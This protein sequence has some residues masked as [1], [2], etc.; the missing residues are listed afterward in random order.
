[1]SESFKRKFSIW[2]VL[3]ILCAIVLFG[4]GY[5]TDF[6]YHLIVPSIYLIGRGLGRR[7]AIKTDLKNA[8]DYCRVQTSRRSLVLRI[9]LAVAACMLLA[10]GF[11]Y[12]KPYLPE[13][14]KSEFGYLIVTGL[15]YSL[16]ISRLQNF[17]NGI[18]WYVSGI[19]LPGER[20]LLIPW[21]HVSDARIDD[22]FIYLTVLDK[23]H[24]F[25][26]NPDDYRSALHFVRWY[27]KK[28]AIETQPSQA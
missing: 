4:S 7:S 23:Q 11:E 9:I 28:K 24:K 22:G 6:H 25:D 20:S 17:T 10:Y 5:L 14:G 16:T 2:D 18:R 27:E 1:M 8:V 21:R 19:K 13:F 3:D 15:I 12:I 26:I